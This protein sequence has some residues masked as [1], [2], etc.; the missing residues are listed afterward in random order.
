M[1]S[2]NDK[3]RKA[4][5]NATNMEVGIAANETVNRNAKTAGVRLSMAEERAAKKV[6]QPRMK[7]DRSRTASRAVAIEKTQTKKQ[8]AKRM[9]A[10]IGNS[11]ASK[12][13]PAVKTVA[14]KTK[15]ATPKSKGPAVLT[16]E[17][18]AKALQ[19]RTSPKGVKEYEKGASKALDKKYPGLYKK[20][21]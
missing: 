18:A 11:P 8:A 3:V 13:K 12:S 14:P 5:R 2:L 21:K 6:L 4:R 16:G 7:L 1:G 20:S 9:A 15:P 17:A 19:K 10:A